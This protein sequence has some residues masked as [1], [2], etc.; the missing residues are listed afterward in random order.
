MANGEPDKLV[1]L[2]AATPQP[3]RPTQPAQLGDLP[4]DEL[5]ALAEEYGLDPDRHRSRQALVAALHE[6]R[7]LVAAID[8][9]ALLDVVR[10]AR[11]PVAQS[12][13]KEELAREIA[14]CRSMRFSGLSRRGMVALAQLRGARVDGSEPTPVV[15]RRLKAC[16]SLLDKLGRKRR[17]LVGHIV[18]SIV[19]GGEEDD[20]GEYR[21][22]P[23]AGAPPPPG[24]AAPSPVAEPT[25]DERARRRKLKHRIE[26]RGLLGG[27][28]DQVRQTADGYVN[29]KLDEVEARIDR[30]LDEIDRRLAEWRDKE[31]A[32]RI[33][34]LKITLWAS[35]I[36]ALLSLAYSYLRAHG[37]GG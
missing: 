18:D 5:A 19:G 2:T 28:A 11:R 30:K 22:L 7:Q 15:V 14:R 8:R 3:A 20:G 24:V 1:R 21:F 10:W 32:N 6:R 25:P 16:E 26:D 13:P 9:D 17:A 33:R 36:V 27:L 23:P 31:V 34:I 4:R 29:Q 35:L 37:M 12:A